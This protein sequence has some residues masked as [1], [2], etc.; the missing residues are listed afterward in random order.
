EIDRRAI[1]EFGIPALELMENAGKGV[2]EE[3]LGFI[4]GSLNRK[5]SETKVL[6]CCGRGNNG[7]DGLVAGRYL[8]NKG[9]PASFVIIPQKS[10]GYGPEAGENLRKA[11]EAGVLEYPW[12]SGSELNRYF[13]GADLLID[14]VLGTGSSGEPAGEVR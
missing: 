8:K 1:K 10:R 13:A 14:A 5:P 4:Q 6:V 9:C 3:T 7:G 12:R 2:A 11:R